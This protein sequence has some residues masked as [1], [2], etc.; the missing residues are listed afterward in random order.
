MSTLKK[1]A[2]ML[3]LLGGEIYLQN[4]EQKKELGRGKFGVV[5]QVEDKATNKIYA[6]KH[7]KTRKKEVKE[8][9]VEEIA[10]LKKFSNP[11][12]IRFIN[13]F[14]TPSEVILVMEYLDG[15]EL[16]ERVADDKF[17]L[18]ES[19]CCLFMRQICRGV[20]YLHKHSIV[21]LD[22][23]PE[24]V[25]CTHKDNT[26]VKIIDFGTAKELEP[27]EQVKSM[28]G[29]PEFVA[30]EVVSYDFI[31]TGTDMWSL[32]VIC[33]IL[34]SGYSPFMGDT[35][36][37]TYNNISN[38][39][40]DFDLEEFDQISKNA[41][42]F[43]SQL[44]K[45][46]PRVRLTAEQCLD[47]PW[48]MEKDIG[49]NVIKTDNLRAFLARRRWQRCGQ[50]IR[51]MRRMK[52]LAKKDGGGGLSTASSMESLLSSAEQS[53]AVSANASPVSSP[54]TARRNIKESAEPQSPSLPLRSARLNLLEEKLKE[55][56]KGNS[57][58]ISTIDESE[59]GFQAGIE[60]NEHKHATKD[61]R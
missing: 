48:L 57:R 1:Q 2:S 18:T 52:G 15:G 10:I 60:S 42:D 25:V 58:L 17:N 40:Y 34:L 43:I 16:F 51:A 61:N 12:I 30:P 9:V 3:K 59:S 29:T 24:N 53:P 46:S 21:H 47:H 45:L 56:F 5:F 31:S 50:A 49:Q 55:E 7:I 14:E 32:G 4:Y 35:D 26:S 37:E 28:C 11:H 19:D 36:A 39:S 38:V 23:K 54:A 33:Y 22:L 41:Q 27:T 20:Q 6:A 44:L 8:K 13:A